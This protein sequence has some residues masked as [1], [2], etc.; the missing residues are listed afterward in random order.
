M[1]EALSYLF[2]GEEV[3]VVVRPHPIVLVRPV[4]PGLAAIALFAGFPNRFTAIILLVVMARVSWEVGLWWVDRYV[5]TTDRILSMSGLITKKVVS[6]PLA[7]ITDLTYARSVGG[8]IFGY[9]SMDLESAGQRDFGRIDHLPDPDQFYRAVMSLALGPRP[10]HHS[11]PQP[12]EPPLIPTVVSTEPTHTR[13]EA[14][15]QDPDDIVV[16]DAREKSSTAGMNPDHDPMNTD[17]IP[18]IRRSED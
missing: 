14:P 5:L 6:L 15:R 12:A 9:G 17:E 11:A 3:A 16:V 10:H 8:R 2:A 7:K 13:P 4:L 18:M 1:S